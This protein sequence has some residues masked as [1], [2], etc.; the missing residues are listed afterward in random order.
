VVYLLKIE[1]TVV[2]YDKSTN[3]I[4]IYDN[5][6]YHYAHEVNSFSTLFSKYEYKYNTYKAKWN[7]H[8]NNKL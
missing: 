5:I 6:L 7:E 8:S 3:T 4:I 2:K 1:S